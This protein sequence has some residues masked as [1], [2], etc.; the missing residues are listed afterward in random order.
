M[1]M[2][3]HEHTR[4]PSERRWLEYAI[5]ALAA[6]FIVLVIVFIVDYRHLRRS[7]VV[8][9]RESWFAAL[10][11]SRGPVTASDIAF[12]RSW[13]TFDYIN[14]LFKTPSNYMKTT[15]NIADTRYPRLT[16]SNWAKESKLSSSAAM[17]ELQDALRQ[18]LLQAVSPTSTAP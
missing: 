4:R 14:K 9:A 2:D 11:H 10:V 1:D 5:L 3:N 16:V 12:V 15:L 8:T 7:T 13:M 6:V 18:Y 17:G